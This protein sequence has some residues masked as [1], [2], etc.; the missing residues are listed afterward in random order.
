[1]S[2]TR[3]VAEFVVSAQVPEAARAVAR[4]SRVDTACAALI[5]E[6]A[7]ERAH[8]GAAWATAVR[9]SASGLA[10]TAVWGEAGA[11][12]WPALA[13]VAR[14]D[15]GLADACCVGVAVGAAL[16]RTGRY[17]EADRG[18]DGTS[19]FG[20]MA[21]AAA[22][23][24]YLALPVDGVVGALGVAAS[25]AG[26]L[27]ANLG[28]DLAPVHAGLAALHGVRAARLAGDGFVGAPDVLEGRIGFGEA[29]FGPDTLPDDAVAHALTTPDHGVRLRSYPCHQDGQA[30]VAA[31]VAA[32]DAGHDVTGVEVAGIAPTSGA[33]RF[34]VP[35]TAAQAGAALRYVLALALVHGTVTHQALDPTSPA[36]EAG[37]LALDRVRIDVSPRWDE[38]PTPSLRVTVRDGSTRDLPLPEP[39][40]SLTEKWH[41]VAAELTEAGRTAAARLITAT[42]DR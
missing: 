17:R 30:L 21:A 37:L 3:L 32:R 15:D 16:W 29:F 31:L 5:G 42:I 22:C 7:A 34:D 23:A 2:A 26:G 11:V 36:G 25:G 27:L 13:A 8:P 10:D 39:D 9:A 35:E 1:M 12:L 24:R 6:S 20:T 28:T 33:V 4:R 40:G 41:R 19:V 18:F 14:D 38:H